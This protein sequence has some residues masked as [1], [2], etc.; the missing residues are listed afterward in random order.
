MNG[1][2]VTPPRTPDPGVTPPRTPDPGVTPPGTPKKMVSRSSSPRTSLPGNRF[3]NLRDGMVFT[4]RC[5]ASTVYAIV[6]C[7][8]VCVCVCVCV[9]HT[10]VLCQNG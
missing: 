8:S 10:P 7:L 6:V 9:C 2:G 1:N 3:V 4:A 5:Y